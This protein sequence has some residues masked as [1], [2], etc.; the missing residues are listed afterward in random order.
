MCLAMAPLL[1][2]ASFASSTMGAVAQYQQESQ[3]AQQQNAF[4][5]Q[6]A[7]AANDAARAAYA[8]QNNQ[9]DQA[10]ASADQNVFERRVQ[11][12]KARGTAQN[13]A[14]EA[15]VTGLSV[16]ALMSDYSAAEG[17]GVDSVDTNFN[18]ERENILA[19]MQAT[20]SQTTARING[21]QRV[22]PPSFLGAAVRIAGGALNA[23]SIGTGRTSSY[24]PTTNYALGIG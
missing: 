24:A 18:T 11:A 1:G 20:Q 16:D 21:V 17:R 19:Q 12:L 4:Y 14:G 9:I 2:I 22:Q 15:G 5:V 7:N 10:R 6:N 13:A 8:N 23:F 3:V